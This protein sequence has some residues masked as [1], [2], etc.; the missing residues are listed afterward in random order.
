MNPY[1]IPGLMTIEEIAADIW[2]IPTELLK[3]H[4]RKRKVIECRYVL[5]TYFRNENPKIRWKYI[6]ERFNM[7]RVTAMKAYT[8]VNDLMEVNLEFKRKHDLFLERIRKV[9]G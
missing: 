9:I 4:T 3:I 2:G 1:V 7:N 6:A 8:T 5:L